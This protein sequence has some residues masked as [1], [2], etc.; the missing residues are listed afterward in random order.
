MDYGVLRSM[1]FSGL[2]LQGRVDSWTNYDHPVPT[3]GNTSSPCRVRQRLAR[4][5]IIHL[6]RVRFFHSRTRIGG[7][8]HNLRSICYSSSSR[9]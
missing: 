1:V 2:W 9:T 7:G 4:M 3:T 8:L 6:G 5:P